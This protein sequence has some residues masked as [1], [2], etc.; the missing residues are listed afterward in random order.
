MLRPKPPIRRSPPPSG[1]S[2]PVDVTP[3]PKPQE[4]AKAAPAESTPEEPQKVPTGTAG[5]DT[6]SFKDLSQLGDQ[7]DAA[8]AKMADAWSDFR[9]QK[10]RGEVLTTADDRL[11]DEIDALRASTTRFNRRVNASFLRRATWRLRRE[12]E[13]QQRAEVLERARE[14]DSIVQRIQ[15]LLG[16][17]RPGEPVLAVWQEVRQIG[18]RIDTLCRR[19]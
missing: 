9:G 5:P 13:E 19:P 18:R 10:D 1:E 14:I 17:A 6:S 12:G 11:R 4:T 7:L 3:T 2:A 8:A 15:H 16:Q